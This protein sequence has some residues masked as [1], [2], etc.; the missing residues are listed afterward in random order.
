VEKLRREVENLVD[1][2]GRLALELLGPSPSRVK[3]TD[4]LDNVFLDAIGNDV[5]S[6]GH[7]Q[8]TG[9]DYSA[10]PA[11][12]GMPRESRSC[13]LDRCDNSSCGC[14]AVLRDVLSLRIE[15]G[16]RFAKPLNAHGASI[17]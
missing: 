5:G 12:S 16:S 17:S 10:R 2:D 1:L 8:F 15:I 9:A 3:Y 4:D 6:A 11:H 7:N 13:R 14:R